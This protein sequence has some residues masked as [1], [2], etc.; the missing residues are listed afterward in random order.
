[1]GKTD[2]LGQFTF[3]VPADIS[4]QKQSQLYTIEASVIDVNNQEVSARAGAVIHKGTFYIG[5]RSDQYI[6]TV[7]QK[8]AVQA[9]TVD[10][11]GLTR[12]QQALTVTFYKQEWYSVKEKAADGSENYYWT[13]KI[14]QTAVATQTI[15]TDARGMAWASF[16]PQEGG[17][18]K[19]VATGLDEFENE[20]RSALYLWVSS[21]AEYINWGQENHDRITLVADKK[22]YRPGETAKIMVPS[23]YQGR[24]NALLT[25]E[26]GKVIQYQ[27]ITL[28]TN[29][30]ILEIPIREEYAPNVFVSVLIVQGAQSAGQVP[31]FKLGYV[32]LPIS[33][34]RQQLKV[35]ITPDKSTYRPRATATYEISTQTYDGK[36]VP[37]EVTLQL[38]DLAVEKLTGAARPNIVDT[39]YRQRGLNVWT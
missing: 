34:E 12:T 9:I 10:T 35:T 37:A 8:L 23:P 3:E 5:L 39:F 4:Q 22:S 36:G 33:T 15:K 25:I 38:V 11:Q 16:T 31:S 6:G 19:V 7:G 27:V 28:K 13:N 21:S 14:R 20:V 24:V 26:R 2:S 30:D 1:T 29:S 32:M 18:Y 17:T